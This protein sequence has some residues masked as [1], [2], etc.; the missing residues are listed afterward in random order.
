[1]AK[2]Y[3]F[4]KKYS[5]DQPQTSLKDIHDGITDEFLDVLNKCLQINSENRCTAD[6]LLKCKIFDEIRGSHEHLIQ[7][8]HIP[9]KID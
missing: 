1:M 5:N 6:E 4:A 8:E 9:V 3:K 7:G 2:F